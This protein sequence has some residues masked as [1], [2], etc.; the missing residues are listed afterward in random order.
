MMPRQSRCGLS[1]TI[2]GFR[3]ASG[4]GG[5]GERRPGGRHW[6]GPGRARDSDSLGP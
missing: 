2:I 5:R 4:P 6:A 3:R 1:L